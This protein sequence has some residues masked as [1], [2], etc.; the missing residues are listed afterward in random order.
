MPYHHYH[1]DLGV[2][3]YTKYTT[4]CGDIKLRQRVGACA[5][6]EYGHTNISFQLLSCFIM[7]VMSH[8][9]R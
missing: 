1:S 9:S 5:V 6:E 7:L 4:I 3:Q 2:V 8:D